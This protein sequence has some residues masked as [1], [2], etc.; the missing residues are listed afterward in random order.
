MKPNVEVLDWRGDMWSAVVWPVGRTAKF[1][2]TTLETA[3]SREINIQLSGNSSGGYS[4]SQ[5]HTPS[6]LE[7][8]VALGCVTKLHILEWPF[9]VPKHKVHL[10]NDHAF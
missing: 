3:Y 10:C 1:S 7:T 4:C 5:L 8:S 6:K 2:K 9:I